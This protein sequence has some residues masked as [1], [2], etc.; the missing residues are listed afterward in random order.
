MFFALASINASG[1][2]STCHL[3]SLQNDSTWKLVQTGVG[4]DPSL[5]YEQ[6]CPQALCFGMAT[7][8]GVV[9]GGGARN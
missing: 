3:H 5:D 7:A 4:E 8:G 1:H 2:F 6:R 9:A